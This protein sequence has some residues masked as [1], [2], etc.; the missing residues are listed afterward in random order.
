MKPSAPSGTSSSAGQKPSTWQQDFLASMVVFLVALPLCMGIALASGAP[1]AAGLVTGIVGGIVVGSIA[2]APL[3][4]SGPAAGLTVICG[5]IIRQ[6]GM[7]AFG[8]AVLF[9]GILQLVAGMLRL[10]QWFRA[11][12]PAVIHGMLSG[13]GIIILCGQLH[14][15]VDEGPRENALKNIAA[16][17]ASLQKGLAWPT[18]ESADIRQSRTELLGLANAL[19][20]RQRTL[21]GAVDRTITRAKTAEE[22]AAAESGALPASAEGLVEVLSP[23]IAEEKLIATEFEAIEKAALASPLVQAGGEAADALKSKLEVAKGALTTT[24]GDL[25]QADGEA[26]RKSQ[27]ATTAAFDAVTAALKSHDWAGKIGLLSV[28]VILAWQFLARGKLKLIPAP[29][30]AIVIATA[31]AQLGQI[32]ILYVDAPANLLAG[33]T[34]PSVELLRESP[35]RQ[36]FVSGAVLALVASAE[37]LLCATATD[38]MHRGPRTRYDKELFAQGVGNTICGCLGVIPMTGVIVRSAAN[39]QAGAVTRLSS[40]LH[41]V[42]L[43]LFSVALTPILRMIPTAALAG[44]LVFTGFRLIDFKGL[45]HLWKENRIEAAIF[46]ITMVVIV[47]E[48]LLAG[49]ITGIVLS[50]VKLLLRFSELQVE[51]TTADSSPTARTRLA[52]SGAATFLRLP[53]LATQLEKVPAGAELHVDVSNVEYIDRA[54]L[55]L[56][57]NWATQHAAMGGSLTIDWD[58]LKARFQTSKPR[59]VK[60]E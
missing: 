10:G 57:Q 33:L 31:V 22:A 9:G 26:I 11:V 60:V 29:L 20:T 43:L 5:E 23:W 39:V 32:P 2:G 25:Q 19:K 51:M 40:I 36:L 14:V 4:V 35:L 52:L 59:A 30:L 13:I 27:K 38:Q 7:Q 56:L 41:G 6:H 44:I 18:W 54:C 17:P 34:L 21:V 16:L 28:L 55:E 24:L 47:V 46:L 45:K 53:K 8:L 1:V 49:V 15:L 42:W 12:S 3:Q 50:A 37:T 48:D 58:S